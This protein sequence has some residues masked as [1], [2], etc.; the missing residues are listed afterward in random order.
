M[1]ENLVFNIML[2]VA[3][4]LG[5]VGNAT[6]LSNLHNLRHGNPPSQPRSEYHES[7]TIAPRLS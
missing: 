7:R 1:P 5:C 3:V 4:T 2:F 6:Y